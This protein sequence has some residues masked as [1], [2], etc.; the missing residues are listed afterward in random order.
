MKRITI[1]L[2]IIISISAAS[3]SKIV[4]TISEKS[5][6]CTAT[7]PEVT[8]TRQAD[9]ITDISTCAGL[10]VVYIQSTETSLT[11]TAPSDII[12]LVRTN[13]AGGLLTVDSERSLG[14]CARLVTVTV[15]SP[16]IR[17]ITASSGGS[18]EASNLSMAGKDVTISTSS[19]AAVSIGNINCASLTIT[20][21]SGAA[22]NLS[23]QCDN[24]SLTA[25]S[26]A[27]ISASGLTANSGVANASSGAVI[28]S[29]ILSPASISNSSGAVVNNR[30]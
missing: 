12:E 15:H 21:S 16:S 20:S 30:K 11:V 22:T 1:I 6:P 25:S 17:L 5:K 23:G 24:A 27:V 2:A 13:V 7:G 29:H 28:N 14:E 18:F 8:Q 4:E 19:G 26:G 3:C 10:K 9:K